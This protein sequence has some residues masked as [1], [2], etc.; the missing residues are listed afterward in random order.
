MAA[1]QCTGEGVGR[2]QRDGSR[3]EGLSRSVVTLAAHNTSFTRRGLRPLATA[4]REVGLRER[5]WKPLRRPCGRLSGLRKTLNVG[6]NGRE[7]Q[8]NV[9]S[10]AAAAVRRPERRV[11]VSPGWRGLRGSRWSRAPTSANMRLP[12]WRFA[13]C[14]RR[15]GCRSRVKGGGQPFAALAVGSRAV[16]KH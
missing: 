15:W 8:T 12:R 9:L 7:R 1:S 16:G 10:T 13:P 6:G 5:R 11:S 14:H 4:G 2:L 3:G